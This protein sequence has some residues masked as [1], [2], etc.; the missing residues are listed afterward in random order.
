VGLWTTEICVRRD[1]Q[2]IYEAQEDEIVFLQPP[3]I[4]VMALSKDD[5]RTVVSASDVLTY[6]INFAN[7][8]NTNPYPLPPPINS[9]P[10]GAAFNVTLTDELPAHTSFLNCQ[11]N[12]PFTGP[13]TQGPPGFVTARINEV[14]V[15]GASGTLAVVVQV[16][17]DAPPGL[18]TDTVS[19]THTDEL[20]IEYPPRTATDVDE[21]PPA[22]PTPTP[23]PIPP[24]SPTPSEKD[25]DPPPA[26]QPPPPPSESAATPTST[27]ALPAVLYLPE[28]GVRE[29][30]VSLIA[31]GILIAAAI[32][33]L[34]VLWLKRARK[35]D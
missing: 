5:G 32:G 11:V 22:P 14:V 29:A 8:S 25:S 18:I 3:P 4:P 9:A 13:C 12:P 15:A 17:A 34:T 21:I 6:T 7:I 19:L 20:G 26:T 2:Y 28:T 33:F 23:T 10:P 24:P 27:P 16:N 30:Q 31:V 35:S 1:N